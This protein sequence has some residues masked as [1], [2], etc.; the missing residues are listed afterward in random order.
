MVTKQPD[1]TRR[2]L[3]ESA[4]REMHRNGFQGAS[5]D[6]IL[7]GTGVTKGAL[8]HH[9]PNKLALGYAVVD[10]MI[11]PM[12][13]NQW[14]GPLQEFDNPI[15]GLQDGVARVMETMPED[16][17]KLGCPLN[18]LIQEMAPID[19]GFRIRLEAVL[20]KWRDGIASR[21]RHGQE[22]GHVRT[23]LDPDAMAAFLVAALEGMAGT[24]KSAQDR[25]VAMAM[26]NVYV[27]TLDT[28]RPTY[29]VADVPT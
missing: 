1:K 7:E 27:K 16:F 18:N 4:M 10:E 24:A 13:L 15:D 23:D 2:A 19:E 29:Q 28:L 14:V 25:E 21:L 26:L 8:Y 3:L 11:A 5:L 12:L 6:R 9:F 22:K 20:D 17:I